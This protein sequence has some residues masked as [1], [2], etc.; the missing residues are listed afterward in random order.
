MENKVLKFRVSQAYLDM[1]GAFLHADVVPAKGQTTQ[2][3]PNELCYALVAS[4]YQNAFL[5]VT[6]FLTAQITSCF[7]SSPGFRDSFKGQTLEEVFRRE[8][9]DLP[10]LLKAASRGLQVDRLSDKKPQLMQLVSEF[11]R[12]Y[13]H[14]LTHP[15]PDR[16]NEFMGDILTK[17]E[18]AFPQSVAR[19]V[20]KFFFE[21]TNTSIPSWLDGSTKLFC[22]PKIEVYDADED[23]NEKPLNEQEGRYRSYS[24]SG[25]VIDFQFNNNDGVFRI[26]PDDCNVTLAFSKA[27][28]STTHAY[29]DRCMS[30]R[31]VVDVAELDEVRNA[32]SYDASSRVR[33]VGVGAI[34]VWENADGELF[35]TKLTKIAYPYL[36][37][38]YQHLRDNHEWV[39]S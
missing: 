39:T 34:L 29:K 8:L 25:E 31:H 6:S 16:F 12:R 7:R 4:N 27:G 28:N 20:I 23:G 9:R 13:R 36:S 2:E 24:L 17:H 19:D 35:A 21:E 14:F 22:V 5:A 30:L 18:W 3:M 33:T 1:A 11:L 37:F 15:E 32:K 10:Q 26:G 38:E